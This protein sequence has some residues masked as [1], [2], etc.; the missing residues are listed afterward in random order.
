MNETSNTEDVDDNV[1]N[2]ALSKAKRF[3]KSC[4]NIS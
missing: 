3:Y 1:R 4:M 2:D